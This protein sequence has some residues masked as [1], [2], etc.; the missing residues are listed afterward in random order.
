MLRGPLLWRVAVWPDEELTRRLLS[1]DPLGL[2]IAGM[3]LAFFV[4]LS[5]HL[6]R[7]QAAGSRS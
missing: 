1:W 4:A 6:W 7:E 2:F 5:I 3:L